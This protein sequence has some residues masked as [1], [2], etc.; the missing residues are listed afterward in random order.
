MKK[1]LKRSVV[2]LLTAVMLL[3]VFITA[4]AA[5]TTNPGSISIKNPILNQTYTV[6][7]VFDAT[8]TSDYKSISY[9]V[10]PEWKDFCTTGD[11][12]DYVAVGSEGYVTWISGADVE[13]FAKKALA[14]AKANPTA[15]KTVFTKQATAED[16]TAGSI[17]ITNLELGQY[18]VDTTVGTLCTLKTTKPQIEVTEKNP[19]P[20]LEKNVRDSGDAYKKSADYSVGMPIKYRL[21]LHPKQG[22]ENYVVHDKM[23]E[24]LQF[25]TANML[26]TD[27]ETEIASPV[28][29]YRTNSDETTALV[30]T[31][32]YTVNTTPTDNDTFDVTFKQTFLDT[33]DASVT[34]NLYYIAE[35]TDAAIST[36]DAV[37]TVNNKAYLSYGGDEKNYLTT[38]KDSATVYSWSLPIYK[39]SEVSGV[40]TPLAGA[41]FV[42]SFKSTR[43]VDGQVSAAEE[44]GTPAAQEESVTET[45]YYAEGNDADVVNGWTTNKAAAKRFTSAADGY[46]TIRGLDS[47]VY[48]IEELTAPAGYQRLSTTITVKI[49]STRAADNTMSATLSQD[50]NEIAELKVLNTTSAE[51]PETGGMGT[52]VLYI[53]GGILVVGAGVFLVV[54]RRMHSDKSA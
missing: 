51:L 5:D 15:I 9:T 1:I 16:V 44:A 28:A 36:T 46:V 14:Y 11:G 38:E 40:E 2:I 42:I 13:A 54:R 41:E 6:Y 12:K 30:S 26:D 8:A 52:T 20:T 21:T 33:L 43:M 4:N 27:G 48:Y 37:S 49:T 45:Y 39:Y 53:V 19:T 24:G 35:L 47:G 50:N 7:K 23:D 31:T 18:L 17:E 32:N 25:S 29:V 10:R 3:S 22:A 34:L